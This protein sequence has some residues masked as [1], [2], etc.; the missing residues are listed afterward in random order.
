MSCKS[1]N[2]LSDE[3]GRQII[4]YFFAARSHFALPFELKRILKNAYSAASLYI[5]ERF[6]R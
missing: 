6:M 3:S 1:Q 4:L 5:S 2:E